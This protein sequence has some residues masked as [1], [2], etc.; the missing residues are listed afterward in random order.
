[1]RFSLKGLM[2]ATALASTVAGS[3]V[4]GQPEQGGVIVTVTG[5]YPSFVD[6]LHAA[7]GGASPLRHDDGT[8]RTLKNMAIPLDVIYANRLF[9]GDGS[10][11]PALD[12]RGVTIPITMF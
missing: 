11:K 8:P 4:A 9:Y 12:L 6:R 1:M 2:T 3:V 7:R 5:S 10:G